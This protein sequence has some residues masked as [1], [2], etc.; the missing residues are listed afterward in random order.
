MKKGRTDSTHYTRKSSLRLP[1]YNYASSGTYFVTICVQP[2]RPAL[3]NPAIQTA[4]TEI[5]QTLPKRFAGV[6]VDEFVIMPDH[7]HG[8]IW[9]DDT[10]VEKNPP[11]LGKVVGAFKALATLTWLKYHKAHKIAFSMPLWQRNY[12]DHIIRNEDD[13]NLT[14]QYIRDNPLKLQLRNGTLPDA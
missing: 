13:L 14:R 6:T 1:T 12:N 10:K 5:W 2:R 9:L 8:I 7:V 4:F 3:A 11:T